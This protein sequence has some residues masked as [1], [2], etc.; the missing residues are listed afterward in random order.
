MEEGVPHNIPST[1][2]VLVTS[3]WESYHF[4]LQGHYSG[5]IHTSTPSN[6]TEGFSGIRYTVLIIQHTYTSL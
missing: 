5:R 1:V 3:V 4:Y 6:R 2:F